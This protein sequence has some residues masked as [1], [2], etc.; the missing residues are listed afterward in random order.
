VELIGESAFQSCTLL[1]EIIITTSVRVIHRFVFYRCS[2]LNAVSLG[3]GLEEISDNTFYECMSL[4]EIVIP[5]RVR[6]NDSA[7]SH[8]DRIII[9]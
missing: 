8:E 5:S 9:S 4:H 6:V 3:E 1:R 7:F 2:N